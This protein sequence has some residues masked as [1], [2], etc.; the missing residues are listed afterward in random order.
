MSIGGVVLLPE[1]FDEHPDARY[2]VVYYQGHFKQSFAT[3]VE[4]R[5]RPATPE[6]K[7]DDRLMAEYS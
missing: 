7:D 1:G 3:P 5:E 4:F 6:L 2:P